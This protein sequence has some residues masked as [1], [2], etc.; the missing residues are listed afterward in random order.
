MGQQT[1]NPKRVI[2][3][4][5]VLL[6]D[7][8]TRCNAPDRASVENIHEIRKDLKTVR[9]Y[10]RLMRHALGKRHSKAG[11]LRCKQAA[12]QLA[13]ARDHVVMLGTLDA[14][15]MNTDRKTTL[16]IGQAKQAMHEVVQAPPTQGIQWGQVADL[17]RNDDAAWSGLAPDAIDPADVKSAW[18]RTRNKARK[19]YQRSRKHPEAEKLHDWRK[20]AKRWL[21][22]EEL[23][24]PEKSKR[25]GRLDKL[26]DL[27]G[28]HHDLA[29]LSHQLWR[30]DHFGGK[31]QRRVRQ[32]IAKQ[33]GPLEKSAL[34]LGKKL[35]A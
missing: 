27:L 20:W 33:R 35:F 1:Y 5:R 31:P 29:V 7:A 9:A 17:I 19:R 4:A 2:D 24:H 25:I 3:A 32:S 23:L 11:N 21:K 22:Q 8:A 13:D 15:S 26:T 6:A 10:W 16:A 30:N 12:G 14:L 34:K 18:Q 28:L